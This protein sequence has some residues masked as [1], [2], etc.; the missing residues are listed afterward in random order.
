MLVLFWASASL[1]S[2]EFFYWWREIVYIYT[3]ASFFGLCFSNGFDHRKSIF[4]CCFFLFFVSIFV[5]FADVFWNVVRLVYA[6]F[7]IDTNIFLFF[8][9]HVNSLCFFRFLK[10]W[11]QSYIRLATLVWHR[12]LQHLKQTAKAI[13]VVPGSHLKGVSN[14]L[15][16][17][18]SNGLCYWVNILRKWM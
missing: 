10:L 6:F 9:D 14:E 7:K 3:F 2:F 12:F 8:F 4:S 13:I 11:I 1:S 18:W 16:S 17:T 15:R 5:A